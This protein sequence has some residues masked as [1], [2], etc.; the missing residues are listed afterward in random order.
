MPTCC[1]SRP[2]S[3]RRVRRDGEVQPGVHAGIR[4]VPPEMLTVER[5]DLYPVPAEPYTATFGENREVS[6]SLTVNYGGARYYVPH[7]LDET[8]VWVRD[9]G[10][11]I[12]VADGPPG[13]GEISRHPRQPPGGASIHDPAPTG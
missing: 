13:A 1:P 3:E 10:D 12:V 11:V 5:G 4:R 9:A 6:W 7:T 2:P 8:G